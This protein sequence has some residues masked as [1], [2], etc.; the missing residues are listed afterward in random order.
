MRLFVAATFP[1]DIVRPLNERVAKVRPRLPSASWVRPEAQHLTFAFIGE[2]DERFVGQLTEQLTVALRGVPAFQ[3]RLQGCGFFPN[4][5][6]ARVGWVGLEPE[7]RFREVAAAV[8]QCVNDAGVKLD[9]TEFKAH[10]TLM[11][12]RDRWPPASIDTF[13]KSLGDYASESFAVDTVIL[14][15]SKLDPRGAVHTPLSKF[16]LHG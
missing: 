4:P 2:Q 11:R 14:Y 10:L 6:H 5:R 7:E 8:R 9:S 1:E 3:A 16:S 13:F 12:I 15:S